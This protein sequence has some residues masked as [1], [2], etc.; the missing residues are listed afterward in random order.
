MENT[1]ENKENL[2][3]NIPSKHI[4]TGLLAHVDAGKTTCIESMLYLS[5]K[6]RKQGRV[7]H[8]DTVL[9]FDEE[10]RK[11]GITIYAKD[12]CFSW[13]G[14]D[15]FVIDTPGH[16]DFSAEMERVLS[17]LDMAIIVINGQDGVQSHTET[18]WKCLEHYDVPCLLFVN[19]MDIS[20]HSKDAL[21][22]DLLKHCSSLCIDWE[23]KEDALTMVNEEIMEDYLERGE[24]DATLV[25][26]AFMSREFFP[27]LYGSALKNEGVEQLLDA[28]SYLSCNKVYP[29][30]FGARVFRISN[31]KEGNRLTHVKVTGGVLVAK[32]KLDE[33]EKVDQIRLYT[34]ESYE[35]VQKAEAGMICTL[36]GLEHTYPGQGLGEEE[37]AEKPLLNGY[38][39]YK[40][41]LPEGADVLQLSDVCTALSS[42]DPQLMIDLDADHHSIHVRIMGE[43][44]ME[45][46]Q[47]KIEER[48][49]ISVGFGTG[50]IVMAET[51][52]DSVIGVG[53]FEPLRH[54]A[55]VVVRLEPLKRGSGVEVVSEVP[56]GTLSAVWEKSILS[57]LSREHKGVL[58]RSPLTDVRIV[59]IAAKGNLKHTSGGDFREAARRAVRQGLMKAESVL[60]EPYYHFRITLPEES[61]SRCLYEMEQKDCTVMVGEMDGEYQSVEGEGP[62]RTLMNYQKDLS[63]Y[64]KGRGRFFFE[65]AGYQEVK[66]QEGIVAERGYDPESDLRNPTGSVF[67]AN[68]A[69]YYVPWA[70]V[71][72]HMH[73]DLHKA[74][75]T[76]GY[77]HVMM[78]VDEK[79]LDG[80]LKS[81]SS[82]NRN[83]KKHYVPKKKKDD[84]REHVE[85]KDMDQKERLMIIDGYNCLY[86][87]SSMEQYKDDAV[88]IAREKLIDV[89][90]AYQAY[91]KAPI[92][93]VFDGYQRKDNSGSSMKRGGLEVIYTRTD[94]TADAWIEKRV[95]DL[96]GKV[97][98]TVV[99]SDALIQNAVLAGGARRMSSRELESEI[100][101]KM[102]I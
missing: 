6:I 97:D 71:E 41:L 44:Q 47:K 81:A 14:D 84:D 83:E 38:L 49:G 19:K 42:E 86:S 17:V 10:E 85:I 33:E 70:D 58:T 21:M 45:V 11:H 62:V 95:H 100:A 88:S 55:E 27:V 26:Q 89:I 76:G 29:E 74:E 67:C 32:Q 40:L 34:G 65:L 91:Y 52:A 93:L 59:L 25:Q 90:F 51:I 82:N 37:D 30:A 8:R 78:K 101:L 53:H 2:T 64:T 54:Y 73:I 12:A 92:Q 60:L 87:W 69:G 18:I 3:K 79:D 66:N 102:H 22:Q 20:H 68:G 4:C 75:S 15:V 36:K 28:V 50:G 31:D 61:L 96:K 99:T 98:L 46:L 80:I 9:D 94:M 13:K 24:L 1:S 16:V 57:H 72:K 56:R 63:A 39:D 77:R 5:G 48:S 35:M 23:N 7:D 43:M